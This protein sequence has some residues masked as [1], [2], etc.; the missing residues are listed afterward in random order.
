MP[1]DMGPLVAEI[2]NLGLDVFVEAQQT[3]GDDAREAAPVDTG[4]L[5]ESLELVVNGGGT[6]VFGSIAFT[7]PQAGWT[8]EGTAAHRVEGN[9]LVFEV[10]GVTIFAT[11]ADIPAYPGTHWFEN[12]VNDGTWTQHVQAA[13]E[14]LS[15]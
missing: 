4:E 8:S 15:R 9:P 10:G 1:V 5:R 14:A 3:L 2:E 7:A 12:A 6:V 11:F 13:L